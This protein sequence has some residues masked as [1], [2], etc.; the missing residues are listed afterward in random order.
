MLIAKTF[1]KTKSQLTAIQMTKM[2]KYNNIQNWAW[3]IVY[4]SH[5]ILITLT[6]L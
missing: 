5:Q 4:S 1:F 3:A 2:L 6:I